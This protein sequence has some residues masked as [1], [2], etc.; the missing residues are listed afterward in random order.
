LQE[1]ERQGKSERKK[2]SGVKER[3]ERK[4]RGGKGEN[5]PQNKFLVTAL[6]CLVMRF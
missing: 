2:Q 3:E 5:A 4:A 1:R 6:L